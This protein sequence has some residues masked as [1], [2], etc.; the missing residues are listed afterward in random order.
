MKVALYARVSTLDKGQ[1]PETQLQPLREYAVL[2]DFTIVEEFVDSGVSG[3]KDRRPALDRLMK[4]ARKREVDAVVVAR[5]D[6]FGRSTR[7]LVTTLEEFQ[8]LGVD[9]VSLNESID[10]STPMGK[11]VFTVLAAVAELERNIIQ[12]R[13]KAGLKRARK[14]G[15]V[16]GRPARVFDHERAQVMWKEGKSLR[17]I[18]EV[19]GV[20]KD[21]VR[22]VLA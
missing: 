2:R 10:T 14:E 6:R 18:A 22:G 19:L 11:M 9:F 4:A 16:L 3:A 5:F 1:N 15:K 12:E 21:T 20:G 17:Q 8:A 13:V 7:H